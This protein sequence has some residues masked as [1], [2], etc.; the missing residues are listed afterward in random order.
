VVELAGTTWTK[1][2]EETIQ[3]RRRLLSSTSAST[4]GSTYQLDRKEPFGLELNTKG[5]LV[6]TAGK[7]H[8]TL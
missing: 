5:E 2:V 7:L 6:W 8:G 4:K 3:K 1:R